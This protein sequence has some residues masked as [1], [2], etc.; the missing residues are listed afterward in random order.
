MTL[1]RVRLGRL[2]GGIVTRPIVDL[3]CG[4]AGLFS[5]S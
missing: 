4:R 2:A 5:V 1:L 3:T